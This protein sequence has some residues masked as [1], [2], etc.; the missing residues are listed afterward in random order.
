MRGRDIKR[1]SYEWVGLWVIIIPAGWTNEKRGGE[2][3]T[4]FIE[5]TLQSL[6][7]HLKQFEAK[8]IKRDDQGDY[9][10]ELRHC[11]YYPEF[12]KEKVV[13][14]P[15]NS[16]YSFT[17]LPV[18]YYFLNS[19]FMVTGEDVKYFCSIFNSKLIRHYLTFIFS[20]EENYT[21]ASKENMQ[22]IPIP[23][24]TTSDE[25]IVKQIEALVDKILAAKKQNPP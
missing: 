23:P 19:V 11:A 4:I 17:I 15:V 6:I 10:W 3:P 22:K 2:K 14:T 12:E 24:I 18:G 13:W 16:E 9:W 20:S 7:K 8:A 21:Y 5:K 25:P 1:Y